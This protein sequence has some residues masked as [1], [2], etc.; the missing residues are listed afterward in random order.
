[1]FAW[2]PSAGGFQDRPRAGGPMA[3]RGRTPP[4]FTASDRFTSRLVT[5]G[6][7]LGFCA[8]QEPIMEYYGIQHLAFLGGTRHFS[9]TGN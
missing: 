4:L 6:V 5:S 8:N 1:M 3:R 2:E 9:A 7:Q